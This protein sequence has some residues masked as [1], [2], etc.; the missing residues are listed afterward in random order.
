MS[1]PVQ[2]SSLERLHHVEK[3]IV[4][5]LELAGSVME[6]LGNSQ[7]PR[8]EAVVGCCREFMLC[9]REIQTTL[10]EKLKSA[11]EYRP[12]RSATAVQGSLSR[13]VTKAGV[14]D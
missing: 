11:C 8:A 1:S 14:R 2:R 12:L 10:R 5:A 4:Q 6:E 7:G 3:R 9:M 13:F